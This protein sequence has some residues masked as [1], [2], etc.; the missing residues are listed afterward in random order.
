MMEGGDIKCSKFFS[1]TDVL[2]MMIEGSVMH[3]KGSVTISF[4]M[5]SGYLFL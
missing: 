5:I 2:A 4:S 1:D 3:W